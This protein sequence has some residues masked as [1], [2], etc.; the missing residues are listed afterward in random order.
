[1]S[2]EE[3]VRD[4]TEHAGEPVYVVGKITRNDAVG[5]FERMV[6]LVGRDPTYALVVTAEFADGSIGQIA[7]GVV[8]VGARGEAQFIGARGPVDAAYAMAESLDEVT[9]PFF[10]G[11]RPIQEQARRLRRR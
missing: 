8:L 6:R 3:L 5:E 9:P 7:A 10:S 1:M 2:V 11:S 4:A